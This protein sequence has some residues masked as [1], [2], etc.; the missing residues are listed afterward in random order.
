[1]FKWFLVVVGVLLAVAL[2][3][4]L[5]MM[6]GPDLSAYQALKEPR[7]TLKADVRVLEVPFKVS[8][9]DLAKVFGTLMRTYFK[10]PGV[11]K[12]PGMPAPAARYE[13]LLDC[14]L[15]PEQLALARQ[16][17]V[18]TGTAGIAVP[19]ALTALPDL[20][21]EPGLT[22][23][24]ATWGYG[25]VAEILYL[26]PYDHEPPT[27]L[28]LRQFIEAQGYEIAGLHEEEYLRGPGM[29][30][31]NPQNYATII[32]YPVKKKAAAAN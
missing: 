22:P 3:G 21:P 5:W 20:K 12:G 1:M 25:E 32:R 28:K 11:P 14:T 23:R 9:Q 18:W 31:S 10:L 29:P 13:N 30:F 26:G 17:I 16:K 15:P 19:A 8:N 4:F 7:L 27:I 24:L 2:G 6:K